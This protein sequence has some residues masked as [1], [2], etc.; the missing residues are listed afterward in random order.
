MKL[1]YWVGVIT[2][3]GFAHVAKADSFNVDQIEIVGAKKISVGTI[4]NS[5][6]LLNVGENFDEERSP[7]VIR[8]LY[9]TGFFD[10]IELLRD[11]NTLII[12]V[13]ERPTIA[14]VNI[15]GNDDI[16]D[17][18]M[19]KALDQIG[20][21]R[22]KIFNELLLEKLDLELQQLYFSLGKYAVKLDTEWRKLD[23]DR[24]AIDI[25]ISEGEAALINSINITGNNIYDEE[26]LLDNFSLEPT[27]AGWFPSD[28]YSSS[29]L[30][31]DLENL[32]SYYQDRGYLQF[33]IESKQVS[34]SPDRKDIHITVN[35]TE[36]DQFVLDDIDISGELV[37]PKAEL[38][39]LVSFRKGQVFSRKKITQVVKLLNRRLGEEGYAFSEVSPI[40]DI[41]AENKSVDIRFLIKPREKMTVRY[42]NFVGNDGTKDIVLRRE[43]RQL[44]GE[45]YRA[46]KVD[47]SR[48]R[49]Q[50][51]NYIEAVNIDLIPVEGVAS[52]LDMKIT[53]RE[54]FSGNFQIG[55]GFSQT[56][57]L[58]LNLGLNHENV[59]GT[60]NTVSLNF[61]N[62][63]ASERYSFRFLDPFYTS[64][65]I[66]RGFNLSFSKT[67]A[68]EDNFTNYLIDRVSLSVE[69]GIPLSEYNT[70]NLDF[71][72]IRNDLTLSTSASDEVFDF[73]I[74]N[75][76]E[77]DSSTDKASIKGQDYDSWFGSIGVSSDS[78]NR[79]IFAE[80]GHLNTLGIQV[81]GGDLNYYKIRYR[82]QTAI[83]VG[84]GVTFGFNSRIGYGESFS[85]TSDMPFFDKFTAGG[86]RSVRG[87]E[88]NSLGP[89][90]SNNDPFGGNFQVITT[91][92]LLFPLES[93]G[94]SETFRLALYFDAGS[95]FA[96][97]N[98][99][100]SNEMR[101]SLG[102]SAKWFSVVGPIEFSYGVPINDQPGDDIRNFQFALGASF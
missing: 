29:K 3:L 18:G 1:L 26:T 54:R 8:K 83:P 85:D 6:P 71:G 17:E 14:E 70:F 77:F 24:V 84:D 37:V 97:S 10:G 48:T 87:Y 36:G 98:S 32:R 5:L 46:G 57:G 7:E 101:Q 34:I 76:D 4:L 49:L 69:Y 94:S 100:E 9:S 35:I 44:E 15:E 38:M 20:L 13:N 80:T 61:D 99:F 67:D 31:G 28:E 59:F 63:S 45:V 95:V 62:S 68:S 2:L 73:V 72:V 16:D 60:G 11:N 55:L 51:L 53:V 39:A 43:L 33:N 96:D 41:D 23:E 91:A 79:R 86:V 82:H 90:D 66:S 22:G 78:R 88:R 19:E 75:S 102:L 81:F 12:K 52:Q 89:R 92:E 27:S 40:P 21:T 65:G 25:D 58:L 93:L 74:A 30:T 50:R 47:R 56:Q 64:S 42:I